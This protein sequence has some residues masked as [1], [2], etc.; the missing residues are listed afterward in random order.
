VLRIVLNYPD[1]ALFDFLPVFSGRSLTTRKK[2][3]HR[4]KPEIKENLYKPFGTFPK[5]LLRFPI[6]LFYHEKSYPHFINNPCGYPVDSLLICGYP[7][8]N[9]LTTLMRK[10][11]QE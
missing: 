5:V 11:N 3:I 6:G 7:V 2:V 4:H 9:L 1:T 10:V 8:D